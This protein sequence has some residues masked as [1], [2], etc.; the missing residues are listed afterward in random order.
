MKKDDKSTIP[1]SGLFLGSEPVDEVRDNRVVAADKGV[2]RDGDTGDDDS[3]DTED[4][5][6]DG[7]DAADADADDSKEADGKD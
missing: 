5:D 2:L 1:S 7:T 4:S 3:V 6:G